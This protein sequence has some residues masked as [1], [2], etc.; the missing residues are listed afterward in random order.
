VLTIGS[1]GH[2]ASMCLIISGKASSPSPITA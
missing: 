1:G 2:P